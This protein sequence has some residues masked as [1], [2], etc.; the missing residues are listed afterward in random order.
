MIIIIIMFTLSHSPKELTLKDPHSKDLTVSQHTNSKNGKEEGVGE[1][2]F[3]Q[4][5]RK[6]KRS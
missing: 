1:K 3:K 5:K 4:H 6:K 2:E